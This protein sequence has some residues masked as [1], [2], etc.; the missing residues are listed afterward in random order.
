MMSSGELTGA[1]NM[2]IS[3]SKI[4]AHSSSGLVENS[5]SSKTIS[6][7]ALV[8]RSLAVANRGSAIHSG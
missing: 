5:A 6:S 8:A 3:C 7:A 4:A 1:Q 2:S